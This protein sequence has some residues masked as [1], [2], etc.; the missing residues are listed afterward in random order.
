MLEGHK[1]AQ[2][3]GKKGARYTELANR[4]Q[5]GVQCEWIE[6]PNFQAFVLYQHGTGWTVP[7]P[8]RVVIIKLCNVPAVLYPCDLQPE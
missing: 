8:W 3:T 2:E 1:R 7:F 6:V 5:T 4:I